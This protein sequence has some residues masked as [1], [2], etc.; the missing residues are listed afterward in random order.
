MVMLMWLPLAVGCGQEGVLA[1]AQ[2]QS[3]GGARAASEPP[4]SPIALPIGP[5][6]E[7]D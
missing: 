2:V 1:V 7:K 4:A 3:S 6:G 5:I